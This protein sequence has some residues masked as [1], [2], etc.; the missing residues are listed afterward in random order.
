M[1]VTIPGAEEERPETIPQ[2]KELSGKDRSISR[3]ILMPLVG[4]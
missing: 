4:W 3:C 2:S 1:L